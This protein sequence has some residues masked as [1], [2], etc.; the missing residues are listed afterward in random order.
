MGCASSIPAHIHSP[1]TKLL[2]G[3]LLPEAPLTFRCAHYNILASYL[4]NNTEP[5]FLY[6]GLTASAEDEAR[7]AAVFEK[8]SATSADGKYMYGGWPNF[9]DG[10]LTPEEISRVET[11]DRETFSWSIREPR[12]LEIVQELNADLMSLVELDRYEE[13]FK[14]RF[15]AMGYESVYK[16]RP[17]KSSLDGCCI[18]Y[19]ASVFQLEEHHSFDYR[20]EQDSKT[21]MSRT[22]PDRTALMVLLSR[23]D[24]QDERVIFCST[25][26]ARNPESQEQ[27]RIR[28]MQT[29][30]LMQQLRAFAIQHN[31]LNV[32]TM[33]AGDLNTDHLE[34]MRCCCRALFNLQQSSPHPI[35]WHGLSMDTAPTSRTMTRNV[36]IDHL[37]YDHS[38]LELVKCV[39]GNK[40]PTSLIPCQK[41]PS[42]HLPIC[43]QMRFRDRS[44]QQRY[45]ALQFCLGIVG[46]TET[47]CYMSTDDSQDTYKWFTRAAAKVDSASFRAA[48]QDLAVEW[49]VDSEEQRLIEQ[50]VMEQDLE[51]GD[52]YLC[53]EAMAAA[54][55]KAKQQAFL[56][57]KENNFKSAFDWIDVDGSGS[58]SKDELV[59]VVV[60]VFAADVDLNALHAVID[61]CDIDHD[62]EIS[63]HEFALLIASTE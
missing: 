34:Q 52:L 3:D 43:A 32:P 45:L 24:K 23:R 19:R 38:S 11:R 2:P 14:P 54:F 15:A 6:D 42:D 63:L 4:G 22:R 17:R 56:V 27:H 28:I 62:G 61:R 41:E 51:S 58:L 21:G 1:G 26:L 31:A 37:V 55:V 13:T 35:L 5:W 48:V 8:Y 53:E 44:E 40:A 29:A 57:A 18:L 50:Q 60:D 47:V 10:I 30:E 49:T 9:V 46:K 39:A 7:R 36:R 20:D 12:I 33:I 16:E 25:H 59:K